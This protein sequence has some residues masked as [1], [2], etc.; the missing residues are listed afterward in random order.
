MTP[1]FVEVL[2]E[3]GCPHDAPVEVIRNF[4]GGGLR[5]HKLPCI[6]CARALG[7]L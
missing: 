3:L 7:V 1:L 6:G 5:R 4:A 2:R